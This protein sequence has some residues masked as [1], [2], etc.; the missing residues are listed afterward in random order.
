MR[1]PAFYDRD[2][3]NQDRIEVLRGSA[4]MLFGR[5][6]TGGAVNQVSKVPRLMTEHEVTTTVG[7]HD[8]GRITGDFN[9]HTGQDAALR[10]NVMKT[11]AGNNGSGSSVDKEGLALGYRWGIGTADEFMASVF[12][13][14]NDNGINYGLPWIRPTAGDSSA[15]NTLIPG[16]APTATAWPATR[17]TA[18]PGRSDWATCT[19]SGAARNCAPRCARAPS[20]ATSAPAPSASRRP[21]PRSRHSAPRPFCAAAP[22]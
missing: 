3:F 21:A 5:G 7:N 9:V 4:S 19:A 22:T 17:V 15:A 12:Y 20:S 14:N 16:L 10:L 13:L 2:I 6:S 1:D 18:A 11:R 8:Y